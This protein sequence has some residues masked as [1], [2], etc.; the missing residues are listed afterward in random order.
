M[1]ARGAGG[2]LCPARYRGAAYHIH[3]VQT[4]TYSLRVDGENVAGNLIPMK[5]EK[6]KYHV[7][8]TV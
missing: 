4:G 7:E 1:P 8:V 3:V 2:V 6:K 5:D